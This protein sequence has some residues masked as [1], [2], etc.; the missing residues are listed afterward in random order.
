MS[1]PLL[2]YFASLCLVISLGCWVGYLVFIFYD[3]AGGPK[4]Q[5]KFV[6]WMSAVGKLAL[7]GIHIGVWLWYKS[8]FPVSTQ[9]NWVL[10]FL[11][12][13]AWWD[14]LLFAVYPCLIV[15]RLEA[16]TGF[17]RLIRCIFI[18]R[19]DWWFYL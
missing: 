19:D 14:F 18:R 10:V 16:V 8:F 13:Q 9:P 17:A 3:V 4:I 2:P 6:I 15:E 1:A 11:A 5:R 12:A 7:A